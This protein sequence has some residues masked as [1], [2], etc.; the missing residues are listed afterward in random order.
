MLTVTVPEELAGPL[1][2]EARRLGTTPELLALEGVRRVLPPPAPPDIPPGGTML[3]FLA[4]Y[5]G[6]VAGTGEAF[7]QDCDRRF[8]DD[9]AAG[10]AARPPDGDR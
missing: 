3:D 6:A 4:G 1:A 9:L 8:A 10:R 5:I 2:D 7:S